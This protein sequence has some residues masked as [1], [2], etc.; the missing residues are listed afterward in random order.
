MT[1]RFALTRRQLLAAGGTAAAA[2]GFTGCQPPE[3]EFM[4]Q[5]R[6]RLAEDTVNAFENHYATACRMCGAGCGTIVRVIEGRAKK[7]E[8]NPD[9][10]VNEGKLCARGNSSVQELYHPDRV[11]SPMSRRALRAPLGPLLPDSWDQAL[12]EL[13]RPL[14]AAQQGGR[15]GDVVLITGPLSGHRALIVDRFTKAYGAQWLTF[16]PDA[17]APLREA[18]RRVFGQDRLPDFDV[19]N[20]HLVLSFGA[21]WL[22]SWISP[23]HLGIDYGMFRQGS[24]RAGAS[25]KPHAAEGKPRGY[26]IHV[27]SHFDGTAANADEWIFCNPGMEGQVALSIAQVIA[28]EGLGDAAALGGAAALASF[29]PDS[30]AARTG[31]DAEKV[32]HA[33]REFARQKPSI[34]IG[35]GT[36]GAHTNGTANLSAILALNLLAGSVNQDG[37]VKFNP[38]PALADLPPPPRVTPLAEF[39]R[40]VQRLNAGQVQAVLVYGANPL[41]ELPASLGFADALPKASFVVSFNSFMDDTAAVADLILPSHLPLEDWGSDIADPAPGQQVVT[42]QQPVVQPVFDTRSFFDVLLAA[43]DDLGGQVRAQ[44]PWR[45]FRD[46]LRE[47]ARKLQGLNRG[48]VRET[49]FE[50][51][52]SKLLQQGGWWGALPGGAAA[53]AAPAAGALAAI[54]G[55]VAQPQFDGDAGQYPYHLVLF[56]HPHIGHGEAAHIPWL[57]SLPDPITSAV[58]RTWVEVNPR[59]AREQGLQEGDI[60]AIEST[61]GRVEV[62]VYVSPA[63]APNVLAMP[64]GWGHK[65]MGRWAKGRGV[66][67]LSLLGRLADETGAPAYAATRVRMSKTGRT[68]RLAKYEGNVEA[69]I[70]GRF[71]HAAEQVLQ[72]TRGDAH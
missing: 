33:A 49:S 11:T 19:R 3:R 50:M 20:A 17:E 61:Q 4:A 69:R 38:A 71:E 64:M 24:Y 30:I 13:V 2:V 66:N 70:Q 22:E 10:P 1:K 46:L 35:G 51:F 15:A 47:E 62:P 67:P 40:L 57:A 27:S 12:L 53:P 14:R 5:S 41:H 43:G 45:T 31:A 36:A 18:V 63:A 16:D 52:W 6:L 8:G 68:T 21:D 9:H 25:F 32:K 44:L 42:I 54:A 59:V 37:G 28:A 48:S 60:V 23:V 26:M 34:A 58:W 65:E 7:V 55:Q 72:V 39:E 56:E 29:A